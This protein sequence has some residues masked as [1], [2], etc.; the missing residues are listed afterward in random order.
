MLGEQRPAKPPWPPG[1]PG[2]KLTTMNPILRSATI[3]ALALG[4]PLAASAGDVSIAPVIV[5][6]SVEPA[7]F[8]ESL[9]QQGEVRLTF[10]NEAAVP[11]TE[12]DF[13][14]SS[15]G[16]VLGTYT[17]RGTFSPGVKIERFFTTQETAGDQKIAVTSVKFADGT[18]WN[19]DAAPQARRQ[20]DV[21][22]R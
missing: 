15:H 16:Q 18:S 11:A 22:A 1:K 2:R 5:S 9:Y 10:V 8:G 13:D 3:A 21:S 4:M 17:D 6:S 14:L 20:A 12:V 19:S 7:S